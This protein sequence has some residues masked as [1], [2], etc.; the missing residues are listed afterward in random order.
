VRI[1]FK[2]FQCSANNNANIV[3]A[4]IF[5]YLVCMQ[6]AAIVLA[7]RTRRVK[8]KVLNDSKY[9]IAL[10]YISSI[11]V[12]VLGVVQFVLGA[13]ININELLTS[14][15]FFI[16]TTSF[17]SLIFIPKVLILFQE[18]RMTCVLST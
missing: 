18:K 13:V 14:G 5:F 16:A 2:V 17:L 7:I 15:V 11:T 6:V 10:I 3:I 9:I 12:L 8:I 1:E 4:I